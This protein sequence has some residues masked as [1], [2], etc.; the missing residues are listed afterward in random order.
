MQELN[1]FNHFWRDFVIGNLLYGVLIWVEY[2]LLKEE[3][4]VKEFGE[5]ESSRVSRIKDIFMESLD[6]YSDIA[7]L[8]LFPHLEKWVQVVLLLS[9][10]LPLNFAA[11]V[12]FN[13]KD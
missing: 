6:I 5:E 1:T 7:Y 9:I 4:I 10:L 2:S 3:D 13:Y 11:F 12:T 8:F